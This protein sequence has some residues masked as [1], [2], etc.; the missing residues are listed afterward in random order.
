MDQRESL[1]GNFKNI[2]LSE[3]KR[4]GIKICGTKLWQYWEGNV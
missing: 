2:K 1:E 3:M 4:Q